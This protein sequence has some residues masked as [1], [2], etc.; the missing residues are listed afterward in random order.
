ML[1]SS[2]YASESKIT[3][4]SQSESDPSKV[5]LTSAKTVIGGGISIGKENWKL[6][7]DFAD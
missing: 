1:D 2:D 3:F 6:M 4:V 7:Y 5:D